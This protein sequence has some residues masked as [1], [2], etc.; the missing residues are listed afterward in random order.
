MTYHILLVD[1]DLNQIKVLDKVVNQQL[2][3]KT[4]LVQSGQEAIDL[5]TTEKSDQF[6]LVIIDLSM[7][8]ING[9]D[10]IN[11]VKPLRPRLPFI[12]RTGFDDLESAV[13]AMKAGASD[14]IQKISDLEQLK[15]AVT[16]LLRGNVLHNEL[17][18]IKRSVNGKIGFD[19]ILG[20]S[21]SVRHMNILAKKVAGSN[22]PTLIEG[23]SGVGKELLARAIHQ[24]SSRNE[25]PFISVNCH[26]LPKKYAKNILFGQEHGT[27]CG[28]NFK[29][30]GKVRE[31]DGGT[32]FLDNVG[33]LEQ[34]VQVKLLRM[35]KYGTIEPVGSRSSTPVNVRLI[36]ATNHNL[37]QQ[38]AEGS[39]LEDLFYRINVFPI[40]VPSLAER[41]SDI[42]QL[43]HHFYTRFAKAENKDIKGIT[44]AA[45][46]MLC[47]HSWPG[48]IRQLKNTIY[49]AVVLCKGDKIDVSDFQ[50]F[51][52][53]NENENAVL[54]REDSMSNGAKNNPNHLQLKM[55]G[56]EGQFR[57]LSDIEHE[58]IRSAI[59]YYQGCLSKV[60]KHLGIGR[61]TLYRK[62]DDLKINTGRLR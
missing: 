54:P 43:I 61:S 2:H 15:K 18:R 29:T 22:I 13:E 11:A 36:S 35:V 41:K 38:V 44:K 37:A 56:P 48:N 14:F 9:V 30:F 5:L 28:A 57:T 6:D 58:T 20:H 40:N 33:A 60:A 45:K 8:Q 51:F 17:S 23:E 3:C 50:H 1:D 12:V 46:N 62:I 32:L 4:T 21:E 34:E 42:P 47:K 24:E 19:D 59:K 49:R 26:A 10:V 27:V 39:F 31:A 25:K 53:P 7:P 55:I 52:S 16:K